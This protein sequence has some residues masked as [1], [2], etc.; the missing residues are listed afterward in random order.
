MGVGLGGSPVGRC[1]PRIE[2]ILKKQKKSGGG[3]VSSQAGG[4]GRSGGWMWTRN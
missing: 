1:E 2:V 3:G 4:G